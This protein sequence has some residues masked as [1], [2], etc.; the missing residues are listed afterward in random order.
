ME[1]SQDFRE[2]LESLNSAKVEYLV[3]GAHALA[4][5]GSP[6]YTGDLDVLVRRDAEN[7]RRAYA[8]LCEFGFGSMQGI[9]ES[10]F[11]E[12]D[13]VLQL[14]YP[15]ARIDFLT[16]I[17]GVDWDTAWQGRSTGQLG[18]IPVHFLGRA[19]LIANKRATGRPKDLADIAALGG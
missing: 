4:H 12:E 19:E 14:G 10:T 5:H 6:R 3:V 7:S 2:L 8:A 16:E 17:S 11:T 18:G 1:I 15:P 9:D 13:L